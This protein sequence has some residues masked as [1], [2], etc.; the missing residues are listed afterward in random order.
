MFTLTLENA[1]KADLVYSYIIKNFNTSSYSIK[2]HSEKLEFKFHNLT[3]L[4][5]EFSLSF[6]DLIIYF[7]EQKL[8]KNIL[9]KNYFYFSD[10]E[11]EEILNICNSMLNDEESHHKKD[12]IFLSVH[13]YMQNNSLMNL[14]GFV[15]FRLKDYIEILDY[16][17]DLAVNNFIVNREYLR[18]IDLLQEYINTSTSK[19]DVV[20]LIYLGKES[21][22]LD[23]S[24]NPLPI[25]EHILDAKYLSDISFS[26]NDYV[27]NTLLNLLPKK[28]YIH[29]LEQED[30]FISTLEKIFKRRICICY[31]CDICNFYKT[32][33]NFVHSDT[34]D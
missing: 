20:H 29:I 30:E 31:E 1:K 24:N 23:D 21:I 33:T 12:L 9:K 3:D 18:F 7:Y 25:D 14:D 27:L 17:V 32:T 10:D 5:R 6:T 2:K 15:N 16:L 26:T 22:L 8:I 13:D 4:Y 28:L 34:S 11:Q 19:I